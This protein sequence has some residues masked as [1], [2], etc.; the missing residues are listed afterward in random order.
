MN[1]GV[2]IID[3][4]SLREEWKNQPHSLRIGCFDWN[5]KVSHLIATGSKDKSIK[6][7]D[8]RDGKWVSVAKGFH[9]GEVCGLHWNQNGL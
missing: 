1:G 5:P 8:M 3:L 6:L 2:K 4:D 7:L 9:F